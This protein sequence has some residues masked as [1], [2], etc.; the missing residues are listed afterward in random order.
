M[1]TWMDGKIRR[2]THLHKCRKDL[3]E[4]VMEVEDWKALLRNMMCVGCI[5]VFDEEY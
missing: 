1:L 5:M 4:V 2:L 3:Y